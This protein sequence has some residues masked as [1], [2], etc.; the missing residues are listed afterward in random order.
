MDPVLEVLADGER[1][2]FDELAAFV[3]IPSVST[4]PEHAGDV[5]RAAAWVEARRARAGPG[6]SASA[7]APR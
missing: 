2:Y 6:R 3:A 4:D 7:V 1:R 5:R